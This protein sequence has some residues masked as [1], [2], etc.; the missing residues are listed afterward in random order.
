MGWPDS[1]HPVSK[2]F[3]TATVTGC[4]AKT[5]SE[6]PYNWFSGE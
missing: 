1:Y 5:K 6:P 2:D 3:R 4:K